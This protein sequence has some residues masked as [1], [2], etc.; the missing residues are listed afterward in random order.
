MPRENSLVR[1]WRY[2]CESFH[3]HV[4]VYARCNLW[5]IGSGYLDSVGM[6]KACCNAVVNPSLE[7][8]M[9]RTHFHHPWNGEFQISAGFT[10]G[11]Q[12]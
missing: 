6:F 10:C 5:L 2:S 12:L 3:G 1:A 7:T 4:D 8:F 11:P 9:L